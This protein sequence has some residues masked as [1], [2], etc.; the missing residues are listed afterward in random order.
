[1][2]E[3]K[4]TITA[5]IFS[6]PLLVILPIWFTVISGVG[7]Y[8][9]SVKF[10]DDENRFR[11]CC[12]E[13][14]DMEI[15]ELE[16]YFFKFPNGAYSTAP[17]YYRYKNKAYCITDGEGHY[18]DLGELEENSRA[19]K[20]IAEIS[21]QYGKEIKTVKSDYDLGAYTFE[22]IYGDK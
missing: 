20:K 17:E 13:Y 15:Y 14:E 1:M 6:V 22:E 11:L 5:M 10:A 16:G 12:A 9:G 2:T 8:D 18:F 21:K 19:Y 3:R 4:K 7:F